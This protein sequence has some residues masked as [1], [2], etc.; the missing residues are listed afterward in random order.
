[1]TYDSQSQSQSQ[2]SFGKEKYN[3]IGRF[4]ES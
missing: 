1:M 2:S 3:L 4:W